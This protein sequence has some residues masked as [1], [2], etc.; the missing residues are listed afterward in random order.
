MIRAD[1]VRDLHLAAKVWKEIEY[2]VAGVAPGADVDPAWVP[3]V[4]CIWFV[5]GTLS[6]LTRNWP[7][8]DASASVRRLGRSR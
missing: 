8:S 1:A 6:G 5:H 7:A 4:E 3:G 2:C